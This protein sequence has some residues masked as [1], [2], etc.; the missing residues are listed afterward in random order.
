MK[1]ASPE[2]GVHPMRVLIVDDH[3]NT[4]TM[5]AR[6]VAQLG[7]QVE[8]RSATSGRE[9]LKVAD[10]FAADLL[11]TDMIMPEMNGL[12]LAEKL[13]NHPGGR[14]AH[15][16]LIT[17]YDVPGL[18]E[19][20]RRA[21]V[22]EI[23]LKPVRPERI[24]QIVENLLGEWN[25]SRP[26]A[27]QQAAGRPHRILVADDR[28]DNV[29]LL[30]RYLENE[31][32]EYIAA[33][34][35]VEALEQA[36]R[37]HPD[38]VLLD[39]NMPKKDGFAVLEEMR[40]D[41]DLRHI[42]VIILTAARIDPSDVQAGFHLGADDYVTKPFDRRELMARIRTKL[43]VKE[44]SDHLL[45]QNRE[46]SMLLEA[47]GILTAPGPIE[48]HLDNVLSLVVQRLG[49]GA[50]YFLD[51]QNNS[52]RV[53]PASAERLDLAQFK[54]FL[55]KDNRSNGECIDNAQEDEAWQTRVGRDVRST[56]YVPL[57]DRHNRSFGAILLFHPAIA[58]FK[59]EHSPILQ[60]IA[61][62]VSVAIENEQWRSAQRAERA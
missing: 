34:D 42:P 19:T 40:A 3:P 31:G 17:A 38:L 58:H 57:R 41:A 59:P 44:S 28:P 43:R 60:A 22:D 10:D 6:A 54:D 21:K 24:C 50:G 8:A 49:A 56:L 26:A 5:L 32:Y 36:R 2:S 62:Q 35:G 20:A 37:S 29:T 30:S 53:F 1:P 18:K 33:A 7:K 45:R 16:I 15:V 51:F 52:Q 23:L 48:T 27:A 13:Q 46:L 11:I 4:A 55:E 39:V 47:T 25:R 9:A 14:P 12:E 61:N